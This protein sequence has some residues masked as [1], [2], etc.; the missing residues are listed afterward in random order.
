MATTRTRLALSAPLCLLLGAPLAC[1]K[2]K[3]DQPP[4]EP[5]AAEGLEPRPDPRL[6]GGDQDTQGTAPNP[7]AGGAA[8]PHGENPHAGMGGDMGGGGGR[9]TEKTPDGRV[10]LG[11]LSGAVPK[12]WQEHPTTSGMRVGQWTVAGKEGEAELVVYYFG[13]GGAGGVDA[14]LD[15]WINQFEQPDGS[16]SKNKSKTEKKT[17]NGM[18]TTLV[19]VTGKYVASMTPGATEKN[20]KPGSMLLGAILETAAG[21]YYFKMVGPQGT[22]TAARK[23]FHD[24]IASMKPAAAAK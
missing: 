4:A 16:P 3:V 17:V 24:F 7:H 13:A 5:T 11:P 18:P 10:V 1:S 8:N 9:T 6:A 22:M 2:K 12:D 19:E 14:N 20:D 23:S 15:R 21:P